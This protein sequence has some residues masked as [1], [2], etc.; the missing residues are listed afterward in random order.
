MRTRKIRG[1]KRRLK[2]IDNWISN[3]KKLDTDYLKEYQRQYVKFRIH[4]WSGISLTNSY[5]PQPKGMAKQKLLEGLFEIYQS[6][7]QQLDKL[8]EDY[9]LKIWLYHPN[10]S[11]SQIVCAIGESKDFYIKTF[12]KTDKEIKFNSSQY[13]QNLN[14]LK[15]E[16]HLE[17][18]ALSHSDFED[19]MEY[20]NKN[21]KKPH[22]KYE[23]YGEIYYFIKQGLVWVGG[24]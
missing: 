6:W 16:S 13:P 11:H 18:L 17:E 8:E 20:L 7:K 9:Y 5:F 15:W 1:H 4:P 10:L 23:H 12:N 14:S 3:N 22:T 24:E 21:L 19:D 2:H